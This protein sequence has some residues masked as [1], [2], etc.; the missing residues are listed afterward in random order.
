MSILKFLFAVCM[1]FLLQGSGCST[2]IEKLDLEYKDDFSGSAR[3]TIAVHETEI[4]GEKS[5]S[6]EELTELYKTSNVCDVSLREIYGYNKKFTA[7]YKFN[8]YE[9]LRKASEC[10]KNT[11]EHVIFYPLDVKDGLLTKDITLKMTLFETKGVFSASTLP[12]E[13]IIAV[14][15]E[16]I[17]V[18]FIYADAGSNLLVDEKSNAAI[19]EITGTNNRVIFKI[20]DAREK[21]ND[22]MFDKIKVRCGSDDKSEEFKRCAGEEWEQIVAGYHH[23]RKTE[24]IDEELKEHNFFQLNITTRINKLS[25]FLK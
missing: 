21:E 14:S 23:K 11:Q 25:K 18:S 22:N 5:V 20:R 10:S 9:E 16:I 12:D 8:S 4:N 6:P 1:F 19:Y 13:L 24:K 7:E 17:N 15:G 3:A 2:N